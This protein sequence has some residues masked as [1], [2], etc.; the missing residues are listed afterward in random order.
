MKK[1]CMF[2]AVLL[3]AIN[4]F[5]AKDI[6]AAEK[7]KTAEEDSKQD[8]DENQVA[9]GIVKIVTAYSDESGN[10]YYAK[11]GT[12]FV[13]GVNKK[14][15]NAGKYIVSDYGIV[16]GE[17]VYLDAIR[18]KY[19][20]SE[21]T[22]LTICYY[23]IG[24]MGVLSELDI[25]SYSS[26]T[27]YVVLEPSIALADKECLKLGEGE[28]VE[29]EGRIHIEGYS[30]ARN[31]VSDTSVEDRSIRVYDTIIKDVFTEQYYND[32]ITYFYVGESIDEGMAGAPIMDEGGS[33]VGMFI[34]QNGSIK[35][36]SVENIRVILD[37]L[38]IKYMTAEDDATYDVP[39]QEQK[40][41]LKE[42]V[43]DNKEYISSIVRNRYTEKTWDSLY[44]A[45][46]KADTVYLDS[47][48]TAKQYDDCMAALKKARKKLRTKAF[49]W[50][51]I[52]I[53]AGVVVLI[54]IFVL[55]RI[56][57]K[58]KKLRRQREKISNM[59]LMN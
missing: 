49:K 34:M 18:K 19:G 53:I 24:N 55:C 54:L 41:S 51:V 47:G 28:T 27:R 10:I 26:E 39:T 32:T 16:Q 43:N 12:G 31:I 56:L 1:I 17:A 52:N 35:A 44:E 45:I 9:K 58:R 5:S 22:K 36:M 8:E 4:I 46:S 48:S 38:S 59:S 20:L 57:R 30:G 21:D 11:Q 40:D 25:V 13:I 14:D 7:D 42:L 3:M 15:E 50:I 2:L 33:V 23:A 6:Y 37:S 29:K